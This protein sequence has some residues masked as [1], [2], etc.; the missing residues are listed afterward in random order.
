MKPQEENT[1]NYFRHFGLHAYVCGCALR[2][3]QFYDLFGHTSVLEYIF[4]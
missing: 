2:S 3:R 4:K 1:V